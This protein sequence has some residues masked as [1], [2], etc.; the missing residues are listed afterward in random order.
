MKI[1]LTASE[2]VDLLLEKNVIKEQVQ[3]SCKDSFLAAMALLADRSNKVNS[4]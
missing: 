1:N 2:L 3:I 4:R